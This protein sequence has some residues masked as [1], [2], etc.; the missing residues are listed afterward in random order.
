MAV[1]NATPLLAVADIPGACDF[2]RDCLGFETRRLEKGYAYCVNG[3]GAIRFVRADPNADLEDEA[4]QVTVYVDV[5]DV[6]A[7]YAAHREAL[8]TLPQG[9]FRPPFE[10]AYGQRE[11]HVI[12]GPILFF[13][14][15]PSQKEGGV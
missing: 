15:Q 7:H 4:R 8:D 3:D 2:L 12:H 14:G 10:Q 1:R 6:D 13:V 5:D 9:Q 11:F